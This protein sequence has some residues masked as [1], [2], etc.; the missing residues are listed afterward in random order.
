MG[1]S[2]LFEAFRL[3]EIPATMTEIQ[4]FACQ[5]GLLGKLVRDE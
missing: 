5:G 4:Q 1:E 3:R 2:F